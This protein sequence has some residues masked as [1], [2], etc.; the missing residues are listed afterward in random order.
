M[1]RDMMVQYRYPYSI[2]VWLRLVSCWSHDQWHAAMQNLERQLA[3]QVTVGDEVDAQQLYGAAIKNGERGDWKKRR[4]EE[5]R[6][7]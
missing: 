7:P 2:Y 4:E 5:K 3:V 6:C 1:H